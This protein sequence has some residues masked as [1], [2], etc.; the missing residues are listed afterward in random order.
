MG[1]GIEASVGTAADAGNMNEP[2]P[3]PVHEARDERRRWHPLW[4][5]VAGIST[6]VL[7]YLLAVPVHAWSDVRRVDAAPAGHRPPEQP[8]TTFLLVGSDSRD[9]LSAAQRRELSTGAMTGGR[10]DTMMLVHVGR[11]PDLLVSIPRAWLVDVP[12]H[13]TSMVG[14][15]YQ[16][17]GAELLVEA[18]EAATGVRVDHYAEVGLLGLVDI[19]DAAGGVTL[20]PRQPMDDRRAG[21]HVRAGCQ[22]AGGATAL[23][24]ARSRHGQSMDDL[25]R[26]THQR[27]LLAAIASRLLSPQVVAD[28]SRFWE[29][30][31]GVADS[32]E[33]S[34]QLGITDA[35]RLGSALHG[36][37]SGDGLSCGLPLTD[38]SVN[39]A[40]WD[41]ERAGP[42]LDA[43]ATDRADRLD[44]SQCEGV[45]LPTP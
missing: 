27:E 45:G 14:A 40:H 39:L 15:A 33:V 16:Y 28:P 5:V 11:G 29:A 38:A 31:H 2:A 44:P 3:V 41:A 26:A 36:I 34:E 20:C 25:S 37:S 4:G 10:A 17:G 32:L 42:L 13:G 12:G 24:Y 8:G 19:V 43:M 35:T 7:G 22:Q 9:G 18:I 1:A 21:L 30:T 6:L 23:A